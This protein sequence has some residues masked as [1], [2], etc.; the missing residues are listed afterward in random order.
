MGPPLESNSGDGL[1][2]L[3][4]F[5]VPHLPFASSLWSFSARNVQFSLTQQWRLGSNTCLDS[6]ALFLTLWEPK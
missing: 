4:G 2:D 1:K 5:Q 6:A 3:Q